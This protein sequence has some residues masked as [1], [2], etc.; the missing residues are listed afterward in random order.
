MAFIVF[1]QNLLVRKGHWSKILYSSLW[2]EFMPIIF[3]SNIYIKEYK[4]LLFISST[5]FI[6]TY[7]L[8][9]INSYFLY[10]L[11][12]YMYVCKSKCSLNTHWFN[13]MKTCIAHSNIFTNQSKLS[14]L[15]QGLSI[16]KNHY[17]LEESFAG[18]IVLDVL[19]Q[20]RLGILQG[21]A[22][23]SIQDGVP[24]GIFCVLFIVLLQKL[25]QFCLQK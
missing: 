10:H 2:S 16:I 3:Y 13:V 14:Q 21:S 6:Q 11:H 5:Y 9:N 18:F 17:L 24:H 7:I 4:F 1:L 22:V 25:L 23:V 15:V 20:P 19:I 12:V 8:K